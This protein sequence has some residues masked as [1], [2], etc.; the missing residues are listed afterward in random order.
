M[1]PINPAVA[2]IASI[3]STGGGAKRTR[4][5][6]CFALPAVYDSEDWKVMSGMRRELCSGCQ[7][8]ANPIHGIPLTLIQRQEFEPIMQPLA[9]THN[10]ANF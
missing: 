4:G 5:E 10:G 9:V 8:L 7:H 6:I 1:Q 2:S 3:I